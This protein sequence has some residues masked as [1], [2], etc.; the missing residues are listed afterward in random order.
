MKK[1]VL[2]IDDDPV[3]RKIVKA[4]LEENGFKSIEAGSGSDG[5]ES[6]TNLTPDCILLDWMMPDLD[7]IETLKE[8]KANENTKHIPV[9][10][11]TAKTDISNVSESLNIGAEDYIVK[12]FDSYTLLKR[13]NKIL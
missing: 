12:P 8:L 5:L 13:L 3:I 10:M 2:V 11:L 6:A 7:G 9:I 1:T 4:N